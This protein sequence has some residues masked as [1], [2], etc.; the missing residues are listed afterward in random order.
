MGLVYEFLIVTFI[1]ILYV[2]L[3]SEEILYVYFWN[4]SSLSCD[5]L[6]LVLCL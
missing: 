2:Y 5:N 6:I 3:L 4:Y 1:L